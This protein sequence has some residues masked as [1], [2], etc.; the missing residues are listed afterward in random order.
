MRFTQLG[1]LNDPYENRIINPMVDLNIPN[2]KKIVGDDLEKAKLF[3]QADT[4]QLMYNNKKTNMKLILVGEPSV[5]L[6]KWLI[7]EVFQVHLYP[8]FKHFFI[9]L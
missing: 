2:L 1:Q 7:F 5:I 4:Y 9:T 8:F 6:E 3:L